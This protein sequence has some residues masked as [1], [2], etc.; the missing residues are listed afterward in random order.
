MSFVAKK[1][2]KWHFLVAKIGFKQQFLFFF[3]FFQVKLEN[4]DP[5]TMSNMSNKLQYLNYIC[6]CG[7]HL[8]TC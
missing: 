8:M 7:A 3:H 5:K 1:N 4:N 6:L 2:Y